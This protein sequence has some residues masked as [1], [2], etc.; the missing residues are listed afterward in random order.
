MYL[1][2]VYINLIY[3]KLKR[4]KIRKI[5]NASYYII[6]NTSFSHHLPDARLPLATPN[7]INH[8]NLTP[9][10]DNTRESFMLSAVISIRY[11]AVM[12]VQFQKDSHSKIISYL[13]Y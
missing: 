11:P 7:P 2:F 12:R 4:K 8:Y 1:Y 13:I 9:L 5:R 6:N 10:V 3:L